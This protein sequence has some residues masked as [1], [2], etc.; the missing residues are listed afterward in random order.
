MLVS[1]SHSEDRETALRWSPTSCMRLAPPLD[2]VCARSPGQQQDAFD[3]QHL[4]GSAGVRMQGLGNSASQ[5][6]ATSLPGGGMPPPIYTL[7]RPHLSECTHHPLRGARGHVTLPKRC[8]MY[9][10]RS[11]VDGWS[12]TV[13]W[14]L[15]LDLGLEWAP[16]VLLDV[17]TGS[18]I[19][20]IV[21][22]HCHRRPTAGRGA[23]RFSVSR[24]FGVGVAHPA[25]LR[26]TIAGDDA[27]H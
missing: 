25:R 17:S 12:C 18:R 16:V 5:V 15:R 27:A 10:R 13:K 1:S 6:T 7:A 3:R 23:H 26:P 22:S 11:N 4:A 9:G 2:V 24:F 19:R 8:R 14:I 20:S 21:S